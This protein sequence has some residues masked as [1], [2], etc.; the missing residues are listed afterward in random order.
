MK[1]R[2]LLLLA[3][4]LLG[5]DS[6]HMDDTTKSWL[7]NV[8]DCDDTTG[9]LEYDSATE[10]WVCRTDAGGGGGVSDG[11]KGDITVSGGGTT[12]NIDAGV[13][14]ATEAAALDAGDVTTG[15]FA[16]GLVVGSSEADEVVGTETDESMCTWEA[17]GSVIDCDLVPSGELGGT[18]AATTIDDGVTVDGWVMGASTA[19]TPAANDNDTSLATSAFVQS[20]IDDGDFLTDNCALENDATPIPDSCVGD[21][22]DSGGSSTGTISYTVVGYTGCGNTT[23]YMGLG[24]T[25]ANCNATESNVRLT[26]AGPTLT[27]SRLKCMQHTDT[28]CTTVYTIMKNGAASAVPAATCTNVG[29]CTNASTTTDTIANGD[30]WSI[31]VVDNASTCT[32]GIFLQCTFVA[33]Y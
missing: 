12:W 25:S 8:P 31:R 7:A 33:T 22:T 32:N 9:K 20:E 24:H 2:W 19:T 18:W 23:D 10:A 4:L 1:S 17:T 28:T 6:V 5:A 27:V 15:T 26:H 13:V 11:D 29:T 30:T 14:G 3:P 16:D 21:G